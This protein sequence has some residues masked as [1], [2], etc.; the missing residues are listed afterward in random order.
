MLKPLADRVIIKLLEHEQVSVGGI[1]LQKPTTKFK[2][3]E[4]M[5]VGRGM[6]SADGVIAPEVKVGD[7][8]YVTTNTGDEIMDGN[9]KYYVVT[10]RTIVAIADAKASTKAKK[11]KVLCEDKK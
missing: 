4:V 11:D 6:T 9:D 7:I 1:I 10:E 5:A 8:V 2:L 3:A